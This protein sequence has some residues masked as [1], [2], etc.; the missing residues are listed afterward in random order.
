[1]TNGRIWDFLHSKLIDLPFP[2]IICICNLKFNYHYSSEKNSL[3][4]HID[5]PTFK[6]C[7]FYN[8]YLVFHTHTLFVNSSIYNKQMR[9]G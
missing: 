6:L 8:C 1:M 7:A 9:H 5:M 4:T 2:L 3:N